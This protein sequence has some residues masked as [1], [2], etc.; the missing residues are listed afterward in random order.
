MEMLILAAVAAFF[1]KNAALD[2]GHMATGRTPPSHAYRMAKL[3]EK[4]ARE[5]RRLQADPDLRGGLKM[6]LRHCYL[7]ACEDL[8]AWRANR[9]ATKPERKAAARAR[10]EQ[11]EGFTARWGWRKGDPMPDDVIDAE[12][13]D[14]DEGL[15]P[16]E[17][18]AADAGGPGGARPRRTSRR[19][20][21][22][23]T[24]STVTEEE[25]RPGSDVVLL[26]PDEETVKPPLPHRRMVLM[27]MLAT[28]GYA[29]D[30]EAI[31][32]MTSEEVDAAITALIAHERAT[33]TASH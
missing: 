20:T 15:T 23:T 19:T 3:R 4:A 14:E 31:G 16:E 30:T 22:T 32:A 27:T 28:A 18:P 17:P 33:R 1:V 8:D 10:R 26:T 11:R 7:D 5:R 12:I 13:V 24:S 25:S 6:V 2:F 9:H 29:P 21:T